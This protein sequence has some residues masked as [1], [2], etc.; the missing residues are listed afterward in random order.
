[1]GSFL[2]EQAKMNESGDYWPDACG[3]ELTVTLQ[4]KAALFAIH[5]MVPSM[6][7]LSLQCLSSPFIPLL[8]CYK[9]SRQFR[10]EILILVRSAY[11]ILF[12]KLVSIFK[13]MDASCFTRDPSSKIIFIGV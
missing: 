5:E 11:D 3:P 10:V 9:V 13:S 8:E 1:M 2:D 6:L 7:T 4:T 12:R